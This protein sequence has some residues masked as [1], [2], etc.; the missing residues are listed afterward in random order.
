[1]RQ[2]RATA[3][4]GRTPSCSGQSSQKGCLWALLA[5]FNKVPLV[6]RR[7]VGRDRFELFECRSQ[8]FGDFR[9]DDVRLG[10]TR[11]VFLGFLLG[12]SQ[13]GQGVQQRT[14]EN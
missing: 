4:I 12:G 3:E 6:G 1:M 13:H 14:A 10:Q 11:R 8:V 5:D 9:G 2:Q 7:E